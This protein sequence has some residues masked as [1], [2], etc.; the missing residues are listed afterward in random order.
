MLLSARWVMI[1]VKEDGM[2][3]SSEV[4]IVDE[5][6]RQGAS[7]RMVVHAWTRTSRTRTAHKM[8]LENV[9]QSLSHRICHDSSIPR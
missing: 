3:M 4:R 7:R 5:H 9:V 1:V 2:V 6:R 8:L